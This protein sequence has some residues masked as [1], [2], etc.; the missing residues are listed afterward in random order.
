MPFGIGAKDAARRYVKGSYHTKISDTKQLEEIE[1]VADRLDAEETVLLVTRQTKSPLK[2]GGSLFTPNSVII[3]D[4][5]IIMR[6]PSTFGLRQKVEVF[7]FD[8]IVDLKLERGVF[9]A[10]IDV[11]VPGLGYSRID[12]I[13]KNDAEQIGRAHV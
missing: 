12:A 6:D 3:T 1:K 5:K 9:S 10:A 7:R 13:D 8:T 2:P 4:R 11:N